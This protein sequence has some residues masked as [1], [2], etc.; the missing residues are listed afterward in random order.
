M[1]KNIGII[2]FIFLILFYIVFIALLFKKIKSFK[3][4]VS[5]CCIDE[6]SDE[7]EECIKLIKNDI[8]KKDIIGIIRK[9]D[10]KCKKIFDNFIE[11]DNYET[12]LYS[13][14]N[15]KGLVNKRNTALDYAKK[16]GY[17]KLI[18][19]DSDIRLSTYT[20]SYLIF[21][22]LF[23]DI[24]CIPYGIRW[25]GMEPVL[26]YDN[27]PR[28]ELRKTGIKPFYSCTVAGMGCTCITLKP[29]NN[30]PYFEYGSILD[31]EGE[32]IGFFLKAKENK[33]K[34][35]ASSWHTVS[36]I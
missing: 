7:L 36:H 19:I 21:N 11:V 26:G 33:I 2:I 24:S 32:D 14:H 6:R 25:S 22:S 20:L 18:F 30:I 27:P 28:I 5:I 17:D 31:I 29:N 34:V 15:M 1:V 16:N 13:R 35:V 8:L 4:L 23:A 9:K 12:H 3:I 10:L